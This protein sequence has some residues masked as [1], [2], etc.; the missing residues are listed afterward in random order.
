MRHKK[1]NQGIKHKMREL[2]I[3]DS[4]AQQ[5]FNSRAIFSKD[6]ILVNTYV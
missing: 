1:Q 5:Y 3:V 6:S 4:T 2:I